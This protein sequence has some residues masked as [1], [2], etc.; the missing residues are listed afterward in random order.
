METALQ[1]YFLRAFSRS[2]N[3]NVDVTRTAENSGE[4]CVMP[5]ACR[6]HGGTTG[7]YSRTTTT[8]KRREEEKD[9]LVRVCQ[10]A[11]GRLRE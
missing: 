1:T 10:L 2:L 11:S 6:P 5:K 9:G 3:R 7:R 4:A 8:H